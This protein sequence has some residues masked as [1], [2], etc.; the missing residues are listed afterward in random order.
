M[1]AILAILGFI[2]L[3]LAFGFIAT[4][5]APLGYEDKAGFHFGQQERTSS[6]ELPYTG[7]RMPQP[8]MA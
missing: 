8:K 4:A 7:H 5:K 1:F 2:A 6:E 3:C